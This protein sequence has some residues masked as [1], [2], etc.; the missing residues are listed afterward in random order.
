MAKTLIA[1][2]MK[3]LSER[4]VNHVESDVIRRNDLQRMLSRSCNATFM[5]T[6]CYYPGINYD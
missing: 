6:V 5:R 2:G 4:G 3:A 1:A